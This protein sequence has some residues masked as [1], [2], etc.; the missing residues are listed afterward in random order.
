MKTIIIETYIIG[1][2]SFLDAEN[3]KWVSVGAD[4]DGNDRIKIF[5][6]N[7]ND[8]FKIGFEFGKFYSD[9]SNY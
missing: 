7:D 1:L 9:E 3:I 8:L 2:C 4:A 6:K 5:F